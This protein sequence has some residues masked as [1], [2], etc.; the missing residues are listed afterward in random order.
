MN[1]SLVVETLHFAT[2]AS[3]I[4]LICVLRTKPRGW[5]IRWVGVRRFGVVAGVKVERSNRVIK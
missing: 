1:G 5:R 3:R 4:W 2:G